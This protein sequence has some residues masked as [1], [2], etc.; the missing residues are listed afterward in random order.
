MIAMAAGPSS[1]TKIAGKINSTKGKISLTVVLAALSSASS[2][3]LGPQAVSELAKRPRDGRSQPLGL[4]QHGDKLANRIEIDA[5]R[6]APP[7]IQT[8]F[9]GPLLPADDEQLVGQVRDKEAC[10]SVAIRSA[11]WSMPNPASMQITSRSIASGRACP[12]LVL[13]RFTAR[14]TNMSGAK[15]DVAPRIKPKKKKVLL[16]RQRWPAGPR[17]PAPAALRSERFRRLPVV[18]S[19][20]APDDSPVRH[21]SSATSCG[22]GR[23]VR[24]TSEKMPLPRGLGGTFGSCQRQGA[25]FVQPRFGRRA[26]PHA[27]RKMTSALAANSAMATQIAMSSAVISVLD[28]N[29]AANHEDSNRHAHQRPVHQFPANLVVEQKLPVTRPEQCSIPRKQMKGIATRMPPVILPW[30]V[31]TLTFCCS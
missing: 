2:K 16:C 29:D 20:Q 25:Q 13:R 21:H 12:I 14:N 1:T 26:A 24:V 30:A 5:I 17:R 31:C 8:R 19:R 28:L 15:N 22:T 11:A 4:H 18:G 9:A 10:N 27:T 3:P 23:E 6:H 7:G